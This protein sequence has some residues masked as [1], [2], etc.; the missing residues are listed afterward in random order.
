MQAKMVTVSENEEKILPTFTICLQNAAQTLQLLISRLQI[1]LYEY[2]SITDSL[3]AEWLVEFVPE[4][5]PPTLVCM[6]LLKCC[7]TE[8]VHC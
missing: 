1:E 6:G 2:N 5:V 3:S 7:N 4:A 8:T